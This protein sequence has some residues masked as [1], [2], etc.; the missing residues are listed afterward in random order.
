[1]EQLNQS[2]ISEEIEKLK[3]EYELEAK[4][5]SHP[6]YT[7]KLRSDDALVIQEAKKKMF[8]ILCRMRTKTRELTK[9]LAENN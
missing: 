6:Y 9:L 3:Q 5:I 2:A 7:S 8:L 4:K 1:M